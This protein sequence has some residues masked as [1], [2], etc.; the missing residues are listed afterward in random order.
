MEAEQAN[1]TIALST[2]GTV[3]VASAAT[4][5]DVWKKQFN[6]IKLRKSTRFAKC[7]K[8]VELRGFLHDPSHRHDKTA[9]A[10]AE[11]E[12]K[13]H[14]LD[15]KKER[16]YYHAKRREALSNPREVLS[17]ILDGADQGSYGQCRAPAH[18]DVSTI[19]AINAQICLFYF[20]VL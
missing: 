10:S 13:A 1:G 16:E 19:F 11:A 8:C 15:I 4:F 14:L 5:Y 18:C 7:D 9:M 6:H 3:H 2:D 12:L 17:I 20:A